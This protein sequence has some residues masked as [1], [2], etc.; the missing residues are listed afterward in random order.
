[1]FNENMT[2]KKTIEHLKKKVSIFQ[3]VY[4]EMKNYQTIRNQMES[5][6]TLYSD[7]ISTSKLFQLSSQTKMCCISY[8]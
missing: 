7:L 8:T 5:K 1:M 2:T 6:L 4:S 3:T